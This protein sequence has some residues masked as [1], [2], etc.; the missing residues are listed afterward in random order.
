MIV[1]KRPLSLVTL[2]SKKVTQT[3]LRG[4]SGLDVI[5]KL[6]KN[7]PTLEEV[8]EDRKR[9]LY[10]DKDSVVVAARIGDLFSD[11]TYNRTEDISYTKCA[12]NLRNLKGFSHKAAGILFAFIRPNL[13]VIVTQGNHRITMLWLIMQDPDTRIS[14]NL[15]FHPE[16]ISH[17]KMLQ[18]EAENHTADCAFRLTQDQDNKFKSAFISRQDWAT[19][20]FAF[21]STYLIGVADT[22]NNAR[23]TC[24]SYSYVQKAIR[25]GNESN[26]RKVLETFTGLYEEGKEPDKEILGNF[27][28]AGSVFLRV[29]GSHINTVNRKN[30]GIDSFK[31]MMEYYFRDMEIETQRAREAGI[32]LPM[33]YNITQADICKYSKDYK[34]VSDLGVCR[35]ISLYNEYVE[36]QGYAIPDRNAT[37]IPIIEGTCFAEFTE[38]LSPFLR[39]TLAEMA[40]TPVTH[41]K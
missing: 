39:Q 15:N 2:A 37:A 35:F 25:E 4:L 16:N 24:N 12:D 36:S 3:I 20:L 21:L 1:I 11:P 30:S 18:V 19:E 26:V 10:T 40:K 9:G 28:R 33:K 41:N 13:E 17:D 22:L 5:D 27:V 6:P 23:F 38:K 32:K 34:Q 7:L 14:V 29:F 8:L 31:E